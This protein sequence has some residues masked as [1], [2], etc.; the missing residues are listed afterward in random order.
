VNIPWRSISWQSLAAACALDWIAGDPRWFPH[1]VRLIGFGISTGERFLRPGTVGPRQDLIRGGLLTMAVVSTSWAGARTLEARGV[2]AQILLA[3]T[4]LAAGSLRREAMQV[5]E[6]SSVIEARRKL[7]MIVGR[8]T[9]NLDEEGIAR[10]VIETVA[11]GLC[12]GVVAPLFMSRSEASL[13]RLLT[14][15]L[16]L[17]I[18]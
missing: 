17:W 15:R 8:D 1:P 4:A 5:V 7:S 9:E 10:A 12:D 16:T 18:R 14:K 3:W 13:G 11:E 2:G 6:A